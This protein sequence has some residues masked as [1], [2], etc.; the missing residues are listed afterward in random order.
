MLLRSSLPCLSTK[1]D[2]T[3][4][5]NHHSSLMIASASGPLFWLIP[6]DL[7]V[8]A[9]FLPCKPSVDPSKHP[10]RESLLR[11]RCSTDRSPVAQPILLS[12]RSRTEDNDY[13]NK[14]F[15]FLLHLLSQ[16]PAARSWFSWCVDSSLQ[17]AHC[18][19][20]IAKWLMSASTYDDLA[21]WGDR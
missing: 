3:I 14:T 20:Y 4:R 7:H 2:G 16:V 15:T 18:K 9:C 6:T 8:G 5:L 12:V 21:H 11:G 17:L 1:Q 10:S 19:Y 13:D